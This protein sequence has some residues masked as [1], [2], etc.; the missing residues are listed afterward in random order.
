MNEDNANSVVDTVENANANSQEI[1]KGTQENDNSINATIENVGQVVDY[2]K[3][4]SESSKEAQR[5][6]QENKERD[7]EIERLRQE[8]LVLKG[9]G[10]GEDHNQNTDNFYP[11]FENL[12]EEARSNLIA[13]TNTVTQRAKDELYRD[14]AIAF[15]KKQYNEQVWDSAFNKTVSQYPELAESKEEF[16]SKYYNVN[17]VP[18]N[19]DSIL[20][21]IAKIHLFDKAKEIGAKEETEKINRIETE[22]TTSGKKDTTVSRSLEDWQ[23][24]SQE[25]PAKFASLSKEYNNDLNSGKI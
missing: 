17:N 3:K 19:I 13:Y 8:N 15:A 22:R 21:D 23:R 18:E 1:N 4:F 20:L 6:F 24:M 11:G 5:L 2:A 10:N 16:K 14:P 12:D 9:N 25:N 7:A